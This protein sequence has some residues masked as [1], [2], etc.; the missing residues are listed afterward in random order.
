MSTPNTFTGGS[1]INAGVVNVQNATALGAGAVS[2]SSGAALEVQ[3]GIT[4]ASV[5]LALSGTGTGSGASRK[6]P[7]NATNTYASG[8]TLA[9]NSAIGVDARTS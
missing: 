2:V 1:A 4:L 6:H 8:V 9:A 5:P 3:G 7:Q